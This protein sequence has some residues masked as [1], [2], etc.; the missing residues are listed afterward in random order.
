HIHLGAA[1][2][3]RLERVKVACSV[4]RTNLARTTPALSTEAVSGV[5]P[6]RDRRTLARLSELAEQW[7]IALGVYGSTA[8]ECLSGETY[9]R[10]DSDV[11]LICDV[12]RHDTLSPWLSAMTAAARDMDGRLDGEIRFPSGAAVAWR[13]LA[14]AGI[15]NGGAQ[16]LVKTLH[17]VGFAPVAALM[18]SLA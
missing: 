16:V 18:E 17:N 1:L 13:E 14:R 11:D 6:D 3:P 2:P 5:L 12:Q 4:A 10:S 15:T 9:R 8:W 7:G